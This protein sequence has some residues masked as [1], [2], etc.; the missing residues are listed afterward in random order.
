MSSL[1]IEL[2]K[3]SYE[4]YLKTNSL[5]YSFTF[6]N[7]NDIIDYSTIIEYLEDN[8]YIQEVSEFAMGYTFELTQKGIEYVKHLF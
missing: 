2:L 5:K 1:D 3:Q 4:H 7:G 6:S 8:E